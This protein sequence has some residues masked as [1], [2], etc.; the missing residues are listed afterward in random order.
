MPR[1]QF[2]RAGNAT[3]A[4]V[5]TPHTL[6]SARLLHLGCQSDAYQSV[7]GLELL[8]GLGG[9][10]DQSKARRL[11]ASKVCAQAEDA[12]LVPVCLVDARQLVAQLILG[13]VRTVGVE[14]VPISRPS[15]SA[16]H[17]GLEKAAPS[18]VGVVG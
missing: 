13:D 15:K 4:R 7:V 18:Q 16:N 11:A 8:H 1:Q 17:Q 3:N 12:D 5:S 10:V 14:D 2:I 6:L 9:V